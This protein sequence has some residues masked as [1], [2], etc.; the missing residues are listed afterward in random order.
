MYT[1][2]LD[3]IMSELN[4]TAKLNCIIVLIVFY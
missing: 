1:N 3:S 4:T 2:N